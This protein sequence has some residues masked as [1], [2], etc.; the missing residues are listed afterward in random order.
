[1]SLKRHP[2]DIVGV[3]FFI[4]P[5]IMG[6]VYFNNN[7]LSK[8]T[9]DCVVRAIS[10]VTGMT[11]DEAYDAICAE[12]YELAE[13]PSTNTAW[14]ALLR[15]MGFERQVVP[16]T[17]PTCYTVRDFC[18]EYPE[19]VYVL[20]TGSHV[21]AV[22]FGDYIDAWDSGQEQPIFYWKRREQDGHTAD[23]GTYAVHAAGQGQSESADPKPCHAGQG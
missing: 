3:P 14:G 1:M 9:G 7:P 6:Y 17:C 12:G 20:A 16:N 11:W 23:G 21:V 15:E 10:I 8:S 2:Y 18:K 5:K 22:V 13:M 19:G 4:Y